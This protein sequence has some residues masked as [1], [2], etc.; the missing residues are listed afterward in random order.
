MTRRAV[1]LVG[2]FLFLVPGYP[3]MAQQPDRLCAEGF[4]FAYNMDFD[5]AIAR[6]NQAI[7]TRPNDPAGYRGL[8]TTTWLRVLFDRGIV[9]VD[10]Y[11]GHLRKEAPAVPATEADAAR[12]RRSIE[13]ALALGEASAARNA[14]SA[15]AHYDV[16]AAVGLMATWTATVEGHVLG[17]IRAAKRAYSEQERVLALDGRRKDAGLIVGTYRYVVANLPLPVRL[18]A[19]VVGFG[20]DGQLGLRM[21]EE[22]AAYPGD[23]QIDAKFALLLLYNR[24]R[25]FGDALKVIRELQGLFPRNRLLW[26]EAGATELRRK[27]PADA[28]AELTAGIDR[29]PRDP[30]PRAFG[31]EAL[32]YYK[33]GVARVL[34]GHL[35]DAETDLR[36]SLA[37]PGRDWVHGRARTELGKVADLRGDRARAVGEYRTAIALGEKDHD[38]DGAAE[39]LALV[40]NAYRQR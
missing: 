3:L 22:A 5:Q 30:R 10:D 27:R 2:L 4:A 32:W 34:L 29:L 20:G 14:N 13:K 31:E 6:F 25:R 16:G 18:L 8:A 21:I 35:Q 23:S 26:L 11:M 24:E 38:P 33:R 1:V 40:S 9:T 12:F 39:A 19:Y 36:A 28:E 15:A 17:G 7:A 37:S